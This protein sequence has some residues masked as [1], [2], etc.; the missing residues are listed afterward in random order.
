MGEQDLR[1]LPM[2]SNRKHLDPGVDI[3]A[4]HMSRIVLKKNITELSIPE[5]SGCWISLDL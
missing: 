3:G 4:D 1:S 5:E 2:E